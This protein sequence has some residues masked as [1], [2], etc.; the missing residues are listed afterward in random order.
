MQFWSEVQMRFF[1]HTIAEFTCTKHC[2]YHRSTVWA[3]LSRFHL[4]AAAVAAVPLWV[5]LFCKWHL[6]WY[7]LVSV[8]AGELLLIYAAGFGSSLVLQPFLPLF[9]G[10]T[11]KCRQCGSPMFLAGRHYDP[12]GSIA[13]H[14]SDYVI[15]TVFVALNIGIWVA[16]LSGKA[17]EIL[18]S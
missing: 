13:P 2:G 17:L 16:L 14:W 8:F 3:N 9:T 10:G 7:Y 4:I 5:A 11:T 15:F 12:L 6:P 1:S 18:T